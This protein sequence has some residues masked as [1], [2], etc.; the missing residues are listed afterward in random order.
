MNY[1]D[2]IR[3]NKMRLR[4]E[5]EDEIEIEVEPSV[6]ERLIAIADNLGYSFM[7]NG[8]NST[9]GTISVSDMLTIYIRYTNDEVKRIYIRTQVPGN[10]I[11]CSRNTTTADNMSVDLQTCVLIIKDIKQKLM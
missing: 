6:E 5:D 3:R 9:E 1:K 4:E 11:D 7:P 8:K 2:L 10:R